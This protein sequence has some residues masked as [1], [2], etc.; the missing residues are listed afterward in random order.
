ME[1]R[2]RRLMEQAI[3]MEKDGIEFYENLSAKVPYESSRK[4]ILSFVNDEK[5][6][7]SILNDLFSSITSIDVGKYL[8]E[9][10]P[11]EKIKTIFDGMEDR[12]DPITISDELS[13]LKMAMDMEE[14][15]YKLYEEARD[16]ESDQDLKRL[17]ARLVEEEKRHY[18][19][20]FNTYDFLSNPEDWSLREERGL[21]DGG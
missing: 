17:W 9:N 8:L 21:L 12:V 15:S 3:Q 2:L 16:I 19:I 18:N 20:F 5:R 14:R 13:A 4:M 1:E 10:Q 6:H 7:L 11:K